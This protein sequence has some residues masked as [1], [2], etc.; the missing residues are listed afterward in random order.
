MKLIRPLL[1]G[2]ALSAG[3]Y[4]QQKNVTQ[5]PTTKELS[6]SIAVGSGQSV[7]VKSGGT[8]TVQSGA[9]VIFA[10]GLLAIDDVSGLQTALNARQPLD[11]TLTAFA[12]ITFAA[13][14]LAYGTGADAFSTT[15]LTSFGRSILD[16]AN[17]AAVRTTMGLG[18]V[19]NTTDLGKP[20][21]TAQAA[22]I[23]VVQADVDA[24]EANTSNPH[25]V[26][27]SQVGLGNADNTSDVNKPVSTAQ[28]AADAVVL[29]SAATDATTKA[30][31]AQAAAIQRA[32]HTG[33][34]AWSTVTKT[35]SSL[36][37]LETRSAG[38][39]SSGTLAVARLP[40]L[41]GGDA[42]TS[43]G[44]GA[45]TLA[46]VNSNV[47]SFGGAT[48]S[49]TATVDGKGRVTA[50]S[51]QTVTPAWS[52]ITS[53]PSTAAAAGF[54]NGATID[55]WG[56]VTDSAGLRGR[57]SD[58]VGTG[59][60]Y[61]VGGALGTP[62]SA[63][64]TN[65]TGLPLT[66][67]VTGALPIANGGTGQ[68]SASAAFT[69]LKQDATTSATGVVELAT[70]AETLAGTS[71]SLALTPA[72]WTYAASV[73]RNGLAPRGGLAFEGTAN[74]RVLTT[75]T[76]QAIGTDA[77]SVSA[78][79]RFGTNAF[80]P[81]WILSS[82]STDQA[83]SGLK[84][85]VNSGSGQLSLEFRNAAQNGSRTATIN[86]FYSQYLGKLVHVVVT[87]SGSSVS[88]YVNG[89]SQAF[90]DTAS[91]TSPPSWADSVASTYLLLGNSVGSD[92]FPGTLHA[93][94]LY[95]LA[96]SAGDAQEIYENGG[97][98]PE[99]YKF[100]SQVSLVTGDN[101][102]FV[103]DTGFW[104]KGG[105]ASISGG[106]ANFS[107]GSTLARG[108]SLLTNRKRYRVAFD[109]TVASGGAIRV[110]DETNW[111]A[112]AT[113]AS[114]PVLHEYTVNDTTPQLYIA[115]TSGVGT[116]TV[117]NL[118]LTQLGAVVHLPL[119]DGIGYQLHDASTNKL[120]AVMT[121]TGISHIIPQR[122][123]YVRGT[124]TWSATHEAK[125]LLGQA[126]LPAEAVVEGII[127]KSTASSSGSG[128]TIGTTNSAA[129][130]V[131]LNAFSATNKRVHTIATATP[132]G[133]GASDTDIIVDPDTANIT[134]TIQVDLRYSIMEG[135]P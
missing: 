64:L 34:Q 66:S 110:A 109:L 73:I 122:R 96:V 102:T 13:D 44:A 9:N 118:V 38:D 126:A 16:D 42:T 45:I 89:V 33:T 79:F 25:S 128:M 17:A 6:D 75:L 47:G 30:N 36:A 113:T 43:A 4:G 53:K 121:T 65:A 41:T 35:G 112:A 23:A 10:D 93:A 14:T 103:S 40:A 3:L 54:T 12:A 108:S 117:D 68:T 39:L 52:S 57:L 82:S 81:I 60:A 63:T 1:V 48:Q 37:D 5:H 125:S 95:N 21:S 87:R 55:A 61:F 104:T 100:G 86:G 18:N 106:A 116:A 94:T 98:V 119:D 31:A 120:D 2:L 76:N 15:I 123:G 111:I 78:V 19:D 99:R 77:F 24:H 20:V 70:S 8:L 90:T 91:G 28:A 56:A 67:G 72:S 84:L 134:A 69:A 85:A 26:T 132:S 22:A 51:A 7:T 131:A 58:E 115:E 49:L 27:K 50:I 32:N 105:G 88:I 59:A 46:T 114:G 127:T 124:L 62:A 74:A 130:F 92:S 129:R 97:E 11:G 29:A 107:A 83:G 101:S 71:S 133:T 80:M 135:T